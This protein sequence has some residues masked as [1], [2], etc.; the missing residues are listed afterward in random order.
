MIAP[1]MVAVAAAVSLRPTTPT[2]ADSE[3]GQTAPMSTRA[4]PLAPESVV[5]TELSAPS[6]RPWSQPRIK[7]T[8]VHR[9]PWGWTASGGFCGGGRSYR[10]RYLPFIQVHGLLHDGTLRHVRY[11]RGDGLAGLQVGM[12]DVW[13]RSEP[14]R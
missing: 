9:G 13:A 8:G 10:V 2:P 3:P 11:A 14:G 5:L 12:R 4:I 1:I 6:P 7:M